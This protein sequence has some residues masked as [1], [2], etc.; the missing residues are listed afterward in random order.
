MYCSQSMTKKCL[1]GLFSHAQWVTFSRHPNFSWSGR[2]RRW[3]VF[4]KINSNGR[5]SK[6][7]WISEL[8]LSLG[9]FP[10]IY[11]CLSPIVGFFKHTDQLSGSISTKSGPL[12]KWKLP[13]EPQ[14]SIGAK[15]P[16]KCGKFCTSYI[17][18]CS[19]CFCMFSV[20]L[21]YATDRYMW[22]RLLQLC[23]F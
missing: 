20:I 2:S 21:R 3:D 19:I 9:G 13:L 16:L 7:I 5:V 14:E 15:R 10:K 23:K 1:A 22:L 12:P 17:S 11:C 18:I 4:P 8:K 6:N